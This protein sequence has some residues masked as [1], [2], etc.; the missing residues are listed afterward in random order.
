MIEVGA[1]GV[2]RTFSMFSCNSVNSFLSNWSVSAPYLSLANFFVLEIFLSFRSA[3]KWISDLFKMFSKVLTWSSSTQSLGGK[4]RPRTALM[5]ALAEITALEYSCPVFLLLLILLNSLWTFCNNCEHHPEK[6][7]LWI[8]TSLN[9][10]GS[11]LNR[12][13]SSILSF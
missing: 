5:E 6:I 12:I 4:T 1:T 11:L 8:C 9:R 10:H 3:S 7:A 13:P 2:C